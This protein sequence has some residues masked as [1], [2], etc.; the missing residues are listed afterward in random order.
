M[1]FAV[2]IPANFQRMLPLNDYFFALDA[3]FA[4]SVARNG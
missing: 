3:D 1:E 4:D 2:K